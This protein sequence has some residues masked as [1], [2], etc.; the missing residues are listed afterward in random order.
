MANILKNARR[1]KT[2]DRGT[3][4]AAG[5]FEDVV[6]NDPKERRK[7]N[8]LYA[9]RAMDRLGLLHEGEMIST[10]AS[11]PELRWLADER[12]ARW[13]ILAELGRIRELVRFEAAVEWVLEARPHTEEAT[14]AIRRF[15][16][17]TSEL[18]G[19]TVD[20]PA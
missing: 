11:K 4:A 18:A 2:P 17:D 15:R 13:A 20:E 9:L 8:R 10:L 7:S 12:G 3:A 14:T 1:L 5:M 6:P 16:V 19:A